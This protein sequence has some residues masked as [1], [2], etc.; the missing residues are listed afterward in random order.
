VYTSDIHFNN[1]DAAG[2][3]DRYGKEFDYVQLPETVI[4][5]RKIPTF[6]DIEKQIGRKIT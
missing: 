4:T 1:N 6:K 3:I 5:S 2:G